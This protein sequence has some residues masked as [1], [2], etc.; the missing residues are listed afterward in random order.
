MLDGNKTTG[1]KLEVTKNDVRHINLDDISQELLDTNVVFAFMTR[2]NDIY[3]K[4]VMYLLQ[5]KEAFK[6]MGLVTAAK[7]WGG[8]ACELLFNIAVQTEAAFFHILD[9]DV[10]P[11]RDTTLRLMSHDLDV[12][13][14]PLWFY[15]GCMNSIHLNVH[16]D[17][18]CLREQTPK[19]PTEGVEKVF[20]TSFGSVLIKRRVLDMFKQSEESFVE[21][22]SLID[23]SFKGA[24][25]DTIFF[26]KVNALGFDVHIDWGC[27]VGTH[28]KFVELNSPTIETFV[29]HRMFDLK[30]GA[31]RK[32][33]HLGT[34]DGRQM[35]A[36]D[37]KRGFDLKQPGSPDS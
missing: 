2:G 30:Y 25:P 26:A 12:V 24:P 16:Y 31:E 21:Y 33:E 5:Q 8:G 18:R 1:L 13:A 22:S 3:Y 9:S 23:E 6:N 14:S 32:R 10:A 4:L 35:L 27:E 19:P 20:A 11:Q 36:D 28:H 17:N 7:M 37:I 15:D 29:A 34:T